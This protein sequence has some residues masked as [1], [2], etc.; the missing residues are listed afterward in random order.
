LTPQGSAASAR[1]DTSAPPPSRRT[2]AAEM[3]SLRQETA[4]VT[5]A[6]A[7]T[8]LQ[9]T[10]PRR[11]PGPAVFTA[12]TPR[13]GLEIT[14]GLC[15]VIRE[16][17]WRWPL[18]SPGCGPIGRSAQPYIYTS[19]HLGRTSSIAARRVV[20]GPML[21]PLQRSVRWTRQPG[22]SVQEAALSV[23]LLMIGVPTGLAV[24]GPG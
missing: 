16:S 5:S 24:A 9:I 20:R 8:L 6:T 15:A 1:Q 21:R 23:Q 10:C 19:P 17:S 7:E 18:S 2:Q 14:A 11:S 22:L 12:K 4:P 3:N 13:N